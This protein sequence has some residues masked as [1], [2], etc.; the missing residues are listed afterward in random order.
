MDTF[1]SFFSKILTLASDSRGRLHRA[2]GIFGLA[3]VRS[4]ILSIESEY[5]QGNIAEIVESTETMA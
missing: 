4:A 1:L 3:S 5:I 2:Q